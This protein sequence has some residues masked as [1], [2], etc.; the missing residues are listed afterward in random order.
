MTA[1][2]S[3]RRGFVVTGTGTDVG[4]TLVGTA[5]LRAL[6]S[7]GLKPGALKPFETGCVSQTLVQGADHPDSDAGRL[8]RAA[9]LDPMRFLPGFFR[10]E[11]PLAPYAARLA[12]AA[13]PADTPADHASASTLSLTRI[14]SECIAFAERFDVT[15]VEGAGGV[16]VPLTAQHTT[17]D[18]FTRL[19]WPLV[20]VA[21]DQLGTLSHTLTAVWALR[22]QH[23]PLLAVVLVCPPSAAIPTAEGLLQTAESAADDPS[24]IHNALILRE[25]LGPLPVFSVSGAEL[26][27]DVDGSALPAALVD[28]CAPQAPAVELPTR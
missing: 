19:G 16:A 28:A 27:A 3:I 11:L 12:G 6:R 25:Y 17:L 7:R 10:A 20:L 21:A 9:G 5:L 22:S 24:R 18:F 23:L 4:K 14:E 13:L 8:S 15:L 2:V 26:I 1:G